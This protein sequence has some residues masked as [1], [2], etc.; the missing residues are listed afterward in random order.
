MEEKGSGSEG[1]LHCPLT[2]LR[3]HT[4]TRLLPRPPGAPSCLCCRLSGCGRLAPLGQ[5]AFSQTRQS[6]PLSNDYSL[7]AETDAGTPG[8]LTVGQK[9]LGEVATSVPWPGPS[10]SVTRLL[11][12]SV[13]TLVSHP[14]RMCQD[15]A[16][17]KDSPAA[18]SVLRGHRRKRA[19]AGHFSWTNTSQL[20]ARVQ[21][22]LGSAALRGK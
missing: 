4:A 3:T 7:L 8:G 20:P 21:S 18:D 16:G 1:R 2:S 11:P 22:W 13:N 5:P 6:H 17:E 19:E 12:C 14:G 15:G 10:G 9:V